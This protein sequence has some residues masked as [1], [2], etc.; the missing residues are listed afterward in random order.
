MNDERTAEEARLEE[1]AINEYLIK[2]YSKPSDATLGEDSALAVAW[3]R[4]LKELVECVV[5]E[6]LTLEQTSERIGLPMQY[7]LEN[8]RKLH[9]MGIIKIGPRRV[10]EPLAVLV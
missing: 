8:L 9:K 1:V 5:D 7:L 2:K 3:A 6:G 4:H 10:N